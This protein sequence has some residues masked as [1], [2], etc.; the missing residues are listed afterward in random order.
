MI[1]SKEGE[2]EDKDGEEEYQWW[3]DEEEAGK[4]E[5]EAEELRPYRTNWLSL[6]SVA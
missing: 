2:E 6:S 5:D 3:E 1:K 4:D